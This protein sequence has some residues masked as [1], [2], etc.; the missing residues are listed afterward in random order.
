MASPTGNAP[1]VVY[2]RLPVPSIPAAPRGRPALAPIDLS[3][4]LRYLEADLAAIAPFV[5]TAWYNGRYRD[6]AAVGMDPVRHYVEA[7]WREGRWP[8]ADFDPGWYLRA[9]PDIAAAGIEPLMHYVTAGH[10]E[11]RLPMR[12]GERLRA[13][14]ESARRAAAHVPESMAPEGARELGIHALRGHIARATAGAFGFVVSVSH[15][16]YTD[17]TGG[18]ELVVG[19]EQKLFGNAQ[20]T[21]LHVSP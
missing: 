19:D 18:I 14:V 11:G 6:I 8:R 1:G 20:F 3:A 12:P 21:Y 7:G 4:A 9:Y 10:A 5:D 17:V 16:R 2:S 13:V 15:D